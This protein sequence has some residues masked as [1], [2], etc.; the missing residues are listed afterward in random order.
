MLKLRLHETEN[1]AYTYFPNVLQA[2]FLSISCNC[3]V[4]RHREAIKILKAFFDMRAL[5]LL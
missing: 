3:G 1:I 5:N 2:A 4:F